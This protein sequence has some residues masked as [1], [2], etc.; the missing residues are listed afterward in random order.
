MTT[1]QTTAEVIEEQQ[2]PSLVIL[3]MRPGE[4]ITANF[5]ALRDHIARILADYQGA[6]F[7]PEYVP[8]AKRDRA[9]LNNLVASINQRRKEVKEQYMAPVVAFEAL[10][11]EL[12]APIRAASAAIDKA[13]ESA[14]RD[15][16]HE[17]LRAHYEDY[18]GALAEAVPFERIDN[19]RWLNKTC[20]NARDEIEAAVERIIRDEAT[21]TDLDLAHPTE[22]KAEYFA[23][24]DIGKAIARS[25][26]VAE[27]IEAARI[28]EE[29]KQAFAAERARAAEIPEPAPPAPAPPAPTPPDPAP[30]RAAAPP[31]HPVRDWLITISATRPDI[32][33][34][35]D[36]ALA[37]GL[38]GR[39]TICPP[40]DG[41]S[42]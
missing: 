21:L 23:T 38:T 8:Q 14:E 6:E 24:L 34:L 4:S 11:K 41:P 12:D 35:I 25:K 32:D 9:F 30:A 39:V 18:A 27:Q 37:L 36:A 40:A 3:A 31:E 28:L 20:N 26:Q 7:G 29:K 5:D 16:E 17:R 2:G 33:K 13:F 1:Q 42:E 19:P 15:A 22:A 10:V